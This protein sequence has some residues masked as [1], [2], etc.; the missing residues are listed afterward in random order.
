MPP[1]RGI[2]WGLVATTVACMLC[3]LWIDRPVAY[4]F[5][6]QRDAPWVAVFR[7]ITH[8]GTSGVWYAVGT[9]GAFATWRFNRKIAHGFMLLL[10]AQALSGCLVNLLK[11]TLGRHRPEALFADGTYGFA[12]QM[13]LL[14]DAG[15]PSGHTQAI[16]AAMAALGFIFPRARWAFWAIALVVA[17]SRIV[18][19][20]HYVADIV[21]G[22][23]IALA[24]VISLRGFLQR[25]A[26]TQTPP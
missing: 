11:I 12:P 13:L 26:L 3:I 9:I 18:V 7:V 19:T 5:H 15:F 2:A 4:F 6:G 23:F 17:F 25:N 16:T 22:S 10:A 24:V 20:K 21:A 1:W 8:A 14:D